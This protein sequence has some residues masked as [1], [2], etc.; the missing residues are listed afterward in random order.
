M[1]AYN[2]PGHV[3]PATNRICMTVAEAFARPDMADRVFWEYNEGA[4]SFG[5]DPWREI[6]G[7]DV[8][9]NLPAPYTL[10]WTDGSSSQ[11][12]SSRPVYMQREAATRVSS[13]QFNSTPQ[14]LTY[15]ETTGYDHIGWRVIAFN[16]LKTGAQMYTLVEEKRR[17]DGTVMADR[18]RQ[19][20]ATECESLA[21][22]VRPV[23][24]AG[25]VSDDGLASPAASNYPGGPT[26]QWTAVYTL[27]QPG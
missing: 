17:A 1:T 6:E 7:I 13:S 12:F 9:A 14:L 25:Y 22:A 23:V 5:T 21:S 15:A 4:V 18:R 3:C 10:D 20:D 26:R 8:T 2:T 24:P 16:D 11:R 27:G 19:M